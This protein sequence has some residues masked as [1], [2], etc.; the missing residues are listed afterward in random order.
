[1]IVVPFSMGQAPY[2]V[3][4]I[5]T[6][7]DYRSSSA[8]EEIT[9]NGDIAY[10]SAETATSGRELWVTDGTELGTRLVKDIYPGFLGSD[11]QELVIFD[12]YLF[13]TAND[14]VHSREL[15]VS[16]GSEAG[17][18]MIIDLQYS[19][20]GEFC[21][22]GIN[23]N[24]FFTTWAEGGYG[25]YKTNV[26]NFNVELLD[27]FRVLLHDLTNL[28]GTLLFPLT[29]IT[30]L[31]ELWKS[32]GTSSGT[33]L[34]RDV[35]TS[36]TS[37]SLGILTPS[38]GILY[39]SADTVGDSRVQH[40][41]WRSDG[42]FSGTF[43]LTDLENRK[44]INPSSL[45]DVQGT[46]FFRAY[47][48]DHGAELW[49]SGGLVENTLLVKDIYPGT[50][51]PYWGTLHA[52]NDILLFLVNDRV[53][54]FTLWKSDG[55]ENGTKIIKES[56]APDNFTMSDSIMYFSLG[57][58]IELWKTDGT[59]AGTELFYDPCDAANAPP[60]NGIDSS[61][62][63]SFKEGL[64]YVGD[65]RS[66]GDLN[67]GGELWICDGTSNGT[68]MVSDIWPGT[69]GS[70]PSNLTDFNGVLHFS[71]CSGETDDLGRY[72]CELLKSDATSNG[73]EF[74]DKW[75]KGNASNFINNF[76]VIDQ[77]LYFSTWDMDQ[78]VGV[79]LWRSDGTMGGTYMVK[80]IASGGYSSIQ[81]QA[82]FTNH[83][84]NLFFVADDYIHGR[85]LWKS[86][87]TTEGTVMVKDIQ[88][89]GS[90]THSNPRYL[91]SV[92]DIVLFSASDGL[93]HSTELWKSDGT[94]QGTVMVK[95]IGK[96]RPGSTPQKFIIFRDHVYFTANDGEFGEELWTS[97]GTEKGTYIVKDIF[98]GSGS[99]RPDYL[100]EVNGILFFVAL[101][102]E[103]DRTI[104]RSDG[105]NENI[106]ILLPRDSN[107]PLERVRDLTDVNGEL[108]FVA[109]S[110]EYRL[111]K[112]DGTQEGTIDITDII[113]R[114]PLYNRTL[115]FS[116]FMNAGGRFVFSV[117]SSDVKVPDV[118]M[119]D[120]T[121][122]GT[123]PLLNAADYN[124]TR[125][126]DMKVICPYLYLSLDD[127]THGYELWAMEMDDPDCDNV[128]QEIDNCPSIKN[129][130]QLDCDGDGIGNVC[131]VV[132]SGDFDGNGL[133]D[134][135]DVSFFIDC[136]NGPELDPDPDKYGCARNC[137]QSFDLHPDQKLDLRDF[138]ALQIQFGNP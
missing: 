20:P 114:N 30:G 82:Y 100:T 31:G 22:T 133:I 25:L 131:D 80:E 122:E 18:F 28:N 94:E 29:G 53:N 79:Q 26:E 108:Y 69:L 19:T 27:S 40:E 42:T 61:T 136:Y 62:L 1:M 21:P 89:G 96:G 115:S 116:N 124:N 15:W 44:P 74:I 97:N 113:P 2:L 63:T 137:L 37:S 98:P 90:S 134:V 59:E 111:W 120:G 58:G 77:I 17:T 38:G 130:N 52:F 4:D 125:I 103:G 65:S 88:P 39:F 86:D 6:L 41:L 85:E 91:I 3:K 128:V 51:S 56:F 75:P 32:D 101:N 93:T 78:S 12:G 54:D 104:W 43:R 9:V 50:E 11:P 99:S 16:D 72:Y 119:T 83:N 35:I 64:L 123:M 138:A 48:P 8:P 118:I 34:V 110:D 49:K 23:G 135:T 105:K 45:V 127:K 33:V 68:H 47:D 102:P 81:R 73:T 60:C 92:G 106:S 132:F 7:P 36:N 126:L 109:W 117:T 87:G 121:V 107:I 129:P 66:L 95:D 24:L 84:G 70:S 14:G 5:N 57:Y 55:T 112:S 76:L 10:F 46:L 67:P 13:F 71:A